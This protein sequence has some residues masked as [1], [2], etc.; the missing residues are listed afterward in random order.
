MNTDINLANNKQV[1]V[2]FNLLI[3][4]V[5]IGLIQYV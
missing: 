5:K 1:I 2:E 3:S 4:N